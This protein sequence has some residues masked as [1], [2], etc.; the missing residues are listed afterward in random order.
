MNKE[1]T[2][3]LKTET[4]EEKLSVG[5]EA[6]VMQQNFLGGDG[7]RVAHP[8]FQEEGSGS[9]PTSPLQ[10]EIVEIDRYRAQKLNEQWH[11]RLPIYDTGFCL[12]SLVSY[13]ALYKNIFYAIAI[14]TNPVAALLPQREWLELRRMAISPEAPKN[15][16]SRM[17]AVMARLI[18]KKF[19]Y[20][21]RLISYQDTEVHKGTIYKAAGW[22]ATNKHKGGSWNRPN[23]K[24]KNGKPRTRPDLNA[25]T[26][27]KVRWEKI[28]SA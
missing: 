13:G 4:P 11:S 7:V 28:L 9:I 1:K 18:E 25:A 16:A 15:T 20:V 14:W 21:E 12:N 24:N 27:E 3:I 8:L 19:P 6:G 17:L 2:K 5:F 10:L 23:A 26:G 22:I